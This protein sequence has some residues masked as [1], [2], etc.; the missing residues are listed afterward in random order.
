MKKLII[1]IA[2]I[3][4]IACNQQ[5]TE[6]Q[7]ATAAKHATDSLLK[8]AKQQDINISQLHFASKTDTTCGMPL[9]AGVED[10]VTIKGKLYGFCAK[11]CKESFLKTQATKK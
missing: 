4:C 6:E 7:K 1:L 9:T 3:C 2:S 8:A 10:T 11:E 5:L